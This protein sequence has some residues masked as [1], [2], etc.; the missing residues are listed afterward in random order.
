LSRKRLATPTRSLA[1]F[2]A[3]L[4]LCSRIAIP[5]QCAEGSPTASTRR[6]RD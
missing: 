1:G 2:S 6:S 3:G 4:R 5:V